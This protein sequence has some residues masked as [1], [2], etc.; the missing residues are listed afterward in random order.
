LVGGIVSRVLAEPSST[1]GRVALD[2]DGRAFR[3]VFH[4]LG[5][6]PPT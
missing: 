6:K 5:R 1:G 2:L 3:R 4:L